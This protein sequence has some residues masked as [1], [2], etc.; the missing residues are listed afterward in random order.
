MHY[1]ET[2]YTFAAKLAV[3]KAHF[4]KLGPHKPQMT[5]AVQVATLREDV[6]VLQR[7]VATMKEVPS[8]KVT[9]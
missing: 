2:I 3:P 8:E 9:E 7:E 1:P 4:E 6:A 5:I